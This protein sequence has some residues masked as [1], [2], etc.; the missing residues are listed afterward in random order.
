LEKRIYLF[1][2]E[3]LKEQRISLLFINFL[4]VGRAPLEEENMEETYNKRWTSAH[5]S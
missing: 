5:V 3:F 1:I 4:P 2:L